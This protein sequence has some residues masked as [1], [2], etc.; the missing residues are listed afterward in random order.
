M[1]KHSHMTSKENKS[2]LPKES[3]LSVII[4]Q[5]DFLF[6]LNEYKEKL[7][8]FGLGFDAEKMNPARFQ[9]WVQRYQEKAK[10]LSL[11]TDF[12]RY[13]TSLL[14]DSSKMTHGQFIKIETYRAENLLPLDWFQLL[15][16]AMIS[17]GL[18]PSDQSNR[19]FV[20]GYFFFGKKRVLRN[21]WSYRLQK[22]K[23]TGKID[24]F[25][26]I[27][28]YSTQ[29]L[30]KA[31]SHRW[32]QE[33]IDFT[34]N[35]SQPNISDRKLSFTQIGGKLFV[36]IERYVTCNFLI[37]H[38]NEVEKKK[39]EVFGKQKKER[40]SKKLVRVAE[41]IV[42]VIRKNKTNS[43]LF[44]EKLKAKK[45]A[46]NINKKE[47]FAGYSRKI[48]EDIG[49]TS[50]AVRQAKHKIKKVQKQSKKKLVQ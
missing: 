42:G 8:N 4:Q 31:H 29:R 32:R 22:N 1:L 6:R 50:N 14:G 35:D 33:R 46:K 5:P 38:W 23:E 37:Q 7:R 9:E 15:A 24:L 20:E 47:E 30:V 3:D 25:V 28:P 12:T 43:E 19:D 40:R 17:V 41:K 48:A 21:L 2:A 36:K 26:E 39:E 10:Q 49:S 16:D 45:H 18:N 27:F 34:K 11:D 13:K 44:L